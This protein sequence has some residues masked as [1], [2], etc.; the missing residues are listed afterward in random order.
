L[1]WRRRSKATRRC[2]RST[3]TVLGSL[4][5][6]ICGNWLES[7]C[8]GGESD[9]RMWSA[10][11]REGALGEARAAGGC[12]RRGVCECGQCARRGAC[13]GIGIEEE[14]AVALAAALQG[15]T[16]LQT[17]DLGGMWTART[18]VFAGMRGR[19]RDTLRVRGLGGASGWWVWSARRARVRAVSTA[20][21]VMQTTASKPRA[22]LRW[23]RGSNATRRCRR[24]TYMVCRFV[25]ACIFGNLRR[26][27]EVGCASGAACASAGSEH[28]MVRVQ[29][30]KSKPRAPLRWRR[31]SN[32]T[33]RCRRSASP[34][35][36]PLC[37]LFCGNGWPRWELAR[38]RA[39]RRERLVVVVRRARV[40][41]VST[42]WCV[43]Q[44]TAS[45]PR[46]PLRWR[47]C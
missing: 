7:V 28:G 35:R 8:V 30:T 33:R 41:A 26:L 46:A 15:N 37:V 21:C 47:R 43:V 32:A 2:G 14:G 38:A 22:P 20:W 3:S 4:A 23:R 42:A 24:W 25:A 16:T 9:R 6:C 34:V 18:R 11:P 40:R 36:G 44:A 31:G 1:R 5:A 13:A 27:G 19:S 10:R 45:K 17:L 12:C 29:A 39:E